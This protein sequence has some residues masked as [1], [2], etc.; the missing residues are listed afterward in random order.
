MSQDRLIP[1]RNKQTGE[2]YWTSKNKKKVERKI[3]LKK[4]SKKLKKRVV[5]KEAKK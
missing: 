3:E 2:V 4:F 1:L 5:F